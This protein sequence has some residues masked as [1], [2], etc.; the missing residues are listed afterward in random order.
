MPKGAG[1]DIL[2]LPW[3]PCNNTQWPDN[4]ACPL[5]R[6]MIFHG[7]QKQMAEKAARLLADAALKVLRSSQRVVI[8]VPGGRSV[9]DIFYH[10]GKL[11]LPWH[12]FHIF[13]LDE[14]LVP[15]HHPESN[16]RL[17][18][19]HMGI[20]IPPTVIRQF[21]HNP[22]HPSRG[23]TA[24]GKE[25]R[26]CGGR[27]NIVLAS[28]GEDGH[29]GSLFP[30]HTSM[31]KKSRCFFVLFDSPKDPPA[32]MTASR[33]LIGQADTGIVVFFGKGKRQALHDF[34]N[35]AMSSRQCPAKII[36]TLP[37]YHL[38]TDQEIPFP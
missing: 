38:L 29:I 13:L 10:F 20:D 26:N 7:P 23:A 30:G 12:R 24:Y 6:P 14:R 28:S 31:E 1:R 27:F 35:T 37:T 11:A 9:A 22:D 34:F 32:R 36:A 5:K 19:E 2:E 4:I 21:L 17:V 33:H 8:A 25:L 16:Y 15:E 3:L 18:R